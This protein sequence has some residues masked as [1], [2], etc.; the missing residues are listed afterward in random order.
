MDPSDFDIERHIIP[1]V[2]SVTPAKKRIKRDPD[3]LSPDKVWKPSA[4]SKR[5]ER[6]KHADVATRS[7]FEDKVDACVSTEVPCQAAVWLFRALHS[8][9]TSNSGD[10]RMAMETSLEWASVPDISRAIFVVLGIDIDIPVEKNACKKQFLL[11][12]IQQCLSM[13]QKYESK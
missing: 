8:A 12:C 9:C 10:Y 1:F 6:G 4:Q 13:A 2:P 3:E 5:S 11:N 7:F